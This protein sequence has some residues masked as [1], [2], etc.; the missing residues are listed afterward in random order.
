MHMR[1]A[2]EQSLKFQLLLQQTPPPQSAADQVDQPIQ[3]RRLSRSL[4]TPKFN[5][6]KSIALAVVLTYTFGHIARI[7]FN[8]PHF[9][10]HLCLS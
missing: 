4:G 2:S 7:E 10:T 9:S 5:E 6:L 8:C 3:T 1:N